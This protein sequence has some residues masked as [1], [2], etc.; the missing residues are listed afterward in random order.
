MGNEPNRACPSCQATG[1]DKKGDHLYLMA[2]NLTWCCQKAQY[3][4]DSKIYLESSTGESRSSTK[5]DVKGEVFTTKKKPGV[6]ER[7][8]DPTTF[9]VRGFREIPEYIY[10]NAG[11][12]CEVDEY[13]EP[14]AFYYP[15]FTH[16]G[17]MLWK[18]RVLPKKFFTS[19]EVGERKLMFFNQDK[20]GIPKKL[21]I[22]EGQDDALAAEYMLGK[23]HIRTVSVPNGANI[24]AFE[25]N[26][27]WL[28]RI[29]EL[30]F[31]PDTDAVGDKLVPKVVALFPKIKILS[32][33]RKDACDMLKAGLKQEYIDSFFRA[34]PYKPDCIK[35][36]SEDLIVEA[37]KPVEWGLSYPFP[38][39]TQKTFGLIYPCVIGIGAGPGSGKTT[40]SQAIQSHILY[41]HKQPVGIIDLENNPG[42]A[43]RKLI[44]FQMGVK[45]HTP[46]TP[47]PP[48]LQEQARKI[49]HDLQERGVV[50]YDAEEDIQWEDVMAAMRYMVVTK[51]IRDVFIDPMSG[52]VAHLSSGEANEYLNKALFS[53]SRL[54]RKLDFALFHI[55]H[56]NNPSTDK[57]HGEGAKVRGSQ[58]SGSRAMWKYSTDIWGLEVNQ[59]AETS[60][61]RSK[62]ILRVIKHRLDGRTGTI[63]LKYN[64]KTGKHEEPG[65]AHIFNLPPPL[66]LEDKEEQPEVKEEV[67]E[68]RPKKKFMKSPIVK[69]LNQ[70]KEDAAKE[71]L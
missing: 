32:K 24:K 61:E 63:E 4:K 10:G 71:Y 22:T 54:T 30:Y 33:P 16:D 48:E 52:L 44:G 15:L 25:D 18:I 13:G 5:L 19:E 29:E 49:G 69:P 68:E 20:V 9:E 12:K 17:D 66:K 47:Y 21:L 27:E 65:V 2:D 41:E 37:T 59:Q 7:E 14:T 60:E 36:I 56:L 70:K 46:D 3:H 1:H 67:T 58:F 62:C 38:S 40:F 28:N 34:A 6:E 57:D 31:D 35:E 42:F 11:V 26:Y 55:N 43:L 45:L 39:L 8:I 23:Y 51:D 53:A 50:F 64:A